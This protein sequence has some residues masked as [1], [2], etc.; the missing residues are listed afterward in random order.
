ML[1]A[2]KKLKN[3]INYNNSNKKC[4]V[5]YRL[6][7][8]NCINYMSFCMQF[9]ISIT[10]NNCNLNNAVIHQK[11]KGHHALKGVVCKALCF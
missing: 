1:L 7:I 5:I 10:A 3:K 8:D 11:N 6:I 4:D 2:P 9:S